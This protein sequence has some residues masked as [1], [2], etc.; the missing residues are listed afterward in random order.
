MSK[1]MILWLAAGAALG[2]AADP[3]GFQY[4]PGPKLQEIDKALAAKTDAKSKVAVEQLG[5]VGNHSFVVVH[6]EANGEAEVHETQTDVMV[7]QSGKATLVV[8]GQVK[9]GKKTAPG[10]VRG[11]SIEGGREIRL[12]PGDVLNVP[13]FM[14]HQ[15]MIGPGE[16][17]TYLIVKVDVK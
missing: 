2:W 16:E 15:V 3:A 12:S 7:V 10:E 11:T 6:R 14:P 8:G 1:R 17:I 5:A 9:E 13:A 4:W